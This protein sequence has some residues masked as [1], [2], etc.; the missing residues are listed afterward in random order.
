MYLFIIKMENIYLILGEQRQHEHR[1]C[2]VPGGA[3]AE[4]RGTARRPRARRHAAHAY[5]RLLSLATA[6]LRTQ[7]QTPPPPLAR[8]RCPRPRPRAGHGPPLTRP[9]PRRTHPHSWHHDPYTWHRRGYIRLRFQVRHLQHTCHRLYETPKRRYG[10]SQL[11][12]PFLRKL[13]RLTAKKLKSVAVNFI[14][15]TMYR[16][17]Y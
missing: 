13:Y 6:C 14:K 5:H 11:I 17:I 15:K 4:P 12:D 3:E 16:P 10:M 2:G 7:T 9:H 8:R 1:A